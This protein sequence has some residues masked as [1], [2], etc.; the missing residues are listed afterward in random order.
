MKYSVLLVAVALTS[1]PASSQVRQSLPYPTPAQINAAGDN[2]Q[3]RTRQDG[4]STTEFTERGRECLTRRKTG[5]VEC[6]TREQWQQ[7]AARL[8]P[9]DR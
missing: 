1:W 7:I 9:E 8:R 4:R 2:Y 3:A 6:R 5:R